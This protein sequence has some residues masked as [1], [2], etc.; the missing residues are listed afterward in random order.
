MVVTTDLVDDIKDIHPSYKWVVGE[1]LANLALAKAYEKE[2]I[3]YSGPVFKKMT[4][5]ET[6]I[7]LEFDN[8]EGGLVTS[9][10]KAPDCFKVKHRGRFYKPQSS[11]IEGNKVILVHEQLQHPAAV[12]FAWDDVARPNLTNKAGLPARPFRAQEQTRF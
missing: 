12:R 10:G 2:N 3:C 7:I 9:D 4:V 8:A 6:K 1:R 5:E 11:Y